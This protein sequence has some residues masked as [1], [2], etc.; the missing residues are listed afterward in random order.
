MCVIELG[1]KYKR[2]KKHIQ[3]PRFIT[4]CQLCESN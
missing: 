2:I 1:A 4:C 3:Y